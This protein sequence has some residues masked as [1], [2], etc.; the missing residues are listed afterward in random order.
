MVQAPAYKRFVG[1]GCYPGPAETNPSLQER[2]D[3]YANGERIFDYQLTFQPVLELEYGAVQQI[4]ADGRIPILNLEFLVDGD[5]R[6]MLEPIL[7]GEFDEQLEEFAQEAAAGGIRFMIRTLHEFN[8]D[9]YPWGLLYDPDKIGVYANTRANLSLAFR[10]VISIFRE[11][12][13]PVEFQ[14]NINAQNG[15]DDP[16]PFSAFWPGTLGLESVA[17]TSYNRAFST[18]NHQYT[19]S[20]YDGFHGPYK[21]VAALTDLPIWVAETGTTSYG[22]DKPAWLM[23]MF[24]SLALDFPRVRQVTFFMLN[25]INENVLTDWDLNTE[26]DINAFVQGV[27]LLR[28]LTSGRKV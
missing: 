25:K 21:Q 10:H 4:A 19:E 27:Q 12:G 2:E 26:V 17:I 23:D 13:A 1:L 18:P 7:A 11:N 5:P 20:F 9:W 28:E 16:R 6:P 14:L 22:T 3:T 24:T 8:G 15:L